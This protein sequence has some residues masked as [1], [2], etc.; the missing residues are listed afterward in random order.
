MIHVPFGV[1]SLLFNL[2]TT[3]QQYIVLYCMLTSSHI[4]DSMFYKT[5]SLLSGAPS[6]DGEDDDTEYN[7]YADQ[8]EDEGEEFRTDRGV[9][10]PR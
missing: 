10:I 8:L 1:L 5:H 7:F 4:A 3:L 2:P 6:H 9:K